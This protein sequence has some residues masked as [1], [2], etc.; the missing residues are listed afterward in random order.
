MERNGYNSSFRE[1]GG[2]LLV[3]QVI[4][5]FADACQ[6]SALQGYTYS[7]SPSAVSYKL[8]IHTCCRCVLE[9]ALEILAGNMD[10]SRRGYSA[11][12]DHETGVR[13]RVSI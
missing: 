8:L 9:S 5:V 10:W 2:M 4:D 3:S 7:H 6:P 12:V 13:T 11:D 1:C